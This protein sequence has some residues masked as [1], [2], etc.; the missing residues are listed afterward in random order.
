MDVAS[1]VVS[2]PLDS[3]LLSALDDGTKTLLDSVAYIVLVSGTS[4]LLV[5]GHSDSMLLDVG[6]S[7][8]RALLLDAVIGL[9]SV[10]TVLCSALVVTWTDDSRVEKIV[11]V[12]SSLAL[13]IGK[14]MLLDGTFSLL[15]GTSRLDVTTELVC[16]ALVVVM[17]ILL[18]GTSRVEVTSMLEVG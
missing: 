7:V 1:S 11:V 4:R 9:F 8:V 17:L 6:I 13:V 18:D 16:S 14:S 3:A 15:L 10:V 2:G 12:T 5:S